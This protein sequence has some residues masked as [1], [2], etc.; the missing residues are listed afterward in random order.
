MRPQKMALDLKAKHDKRKRDLDDKQPNS[1]A[2][3][4]QRTDIPED[5]R[6]AILSVLDEVKVTNDNTS[7]NTV[8]YQ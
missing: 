7:S 2:P 4:R 1:P 3:K 5:L 8:T 6:E